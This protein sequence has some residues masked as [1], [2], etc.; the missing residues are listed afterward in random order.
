MSSQTYPV[1][2]GLAGP[3]PIALLLAIVSFLL[4]INKLIL[5]KTLHVIATGPA[6]TVAML[7]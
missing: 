7:T 3:T 1:I 6:A 2:A 4:A 5:H